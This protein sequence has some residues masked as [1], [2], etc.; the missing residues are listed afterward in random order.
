MAARRAGRTPVSSA[1]TLRSGGRAVAGTVWE[2]VRAAAGSTGAATA[3]RTS[4]ESV[5]Y[6]DLLGLA[7]R[8]AAL[9]RAAVP[10]GSLLAIED[11]GHAG[12][13]VALLAAARARCAVLPLNPADPR[14]LRDAVL[15][16][17]APAAVISSADA[18]EPE[19]AVRPL[20]RQ[21]DSR[22]RSFEDVAYVMYTSGSTGEPKGVQVSHA[23]LVARLRGLAEVP[24]L[25]AGDSMAAMTA[26]TFD[27][28]LAEL[29]L[30]LT[31]G[32]RVEIAPSDA[33]ADPASFA[34]F[35]AARAPTVIQATPSF[36]R[37]VLASGWKGLPGCRVWCGGEALTAPLARQLLARCG[38]LWN[39]YG[40]TEATI[41]ASASRIRSADQIGLGKP[42]PGSGLFLAIEPVL[43]GDAGETCD[44]SSADQVGEVML[45]GD[46]LADGY[47]DAS[48]LTG[49]R[50]VLFDTPD[51]RRRCYR[52]GDL[53]R[54][55][56]DGV[57]EFVGRRDGQVKLRGHRVELGMIEAVLEEHPQVSQAVAVMREAANPDRAHIAAF[58]VLT[59]APVSP[60][61]LRSWLADRLPSS[62]RPARIFVLDELPR[63]AAG[64]IDRVTLTTWPT[65]GSV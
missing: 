61:R 45:Y 33:R 11:C 5:S 24:G 21:T 34:T 27:I 22:P 16:Q 18:D 12:A 3:L 44:A 32:A 10:R 54:R 26:L 41:W 31:V 39:L 17:A 58:T 2:E 43:A 59:G 28:V 23:A 36:W 15:R 42:L 50:F 9:I 47:L 40:P 46:G 1:E 52:T 8:A 64:K 4:R 60:R 29:L 56:P 35:A 57:I 65:T 13:A 20:A 25:R 7:E 51:G 49:C 63:T 6:A 37:L 14:R 38:Q 48:E 30:P 62:S 53:A 19:V 55:R